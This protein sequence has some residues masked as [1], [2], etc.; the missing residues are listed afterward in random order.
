MNCESIDPSLALGFLCIDRQDYLD[1]CERIKCLQ[2]EFTIYCPFSVADRRPDYTCATS[3]LEHLMMECLSTTGEDGS[4][5]I[6]GRIGGGKEEE[7]KETDEEE[8]VMI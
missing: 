7:E 6:G 4:D 2:K 1:F 8:Y 5:T 3:D